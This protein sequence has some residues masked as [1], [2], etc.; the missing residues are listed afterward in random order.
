MFSELQKRPVSRTQCITVILF[1]DAL[2]CWLTAV[3]GA[4]HAD[5]TAIVIS[6]EF[7]VTRRWE[8]ILGLHVLTPCVQVKTG[9]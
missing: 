9:A 3:Y 6:L 7:K 4:A 2:A 1:I 8:L 5:I